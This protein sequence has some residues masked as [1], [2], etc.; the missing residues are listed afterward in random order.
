MASE[1]PSSNALSR[2]I[3]PLL[4]VS[5]KVMKIVANRHF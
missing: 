1:L 4:P 3:D 2:I 5:L